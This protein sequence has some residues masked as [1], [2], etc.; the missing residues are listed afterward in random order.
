LSVLIFC[1]LVL[2]VLE[3]VLFHIEYGKKTGFFDSDNGIGCLSRMEEGM[4]K[5]V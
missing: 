2:T 3:R 5:P 4:V 1:K